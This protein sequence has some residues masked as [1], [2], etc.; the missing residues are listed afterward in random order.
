[1]KQSSLYELP[2]YLKQLQPIPYP[3]TLRIEERELLEDCEKWSLKNLTQK[4][5]D[6]LS[7]LKGSPETRED[8][9]KRLHVLTEKYF[10]HQEAWRAKIHEGDS[11]MS[12]MK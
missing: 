8:L 4:F 11:R 5:L 10:K 12:S 2:N 1:M 6:R 7:H 3:D 9:V